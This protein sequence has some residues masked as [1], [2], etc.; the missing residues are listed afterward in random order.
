MLVVLLLASWRF[1]EDP[2]S[3]T[4]PTPNALNPTVM[5]KVRLFILLFLSF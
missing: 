3:A 1:A 4:S 2:G 5:Q